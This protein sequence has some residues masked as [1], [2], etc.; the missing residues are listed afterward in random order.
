MAWWR[1]PS[2]QTPTWSREDDHTAFTVTIKAQIEQGVAPWQQSWTPGE[3][4]LP[5]HLVSG[6]AYRGVNA[7]HLSVVQTA[8]DYRDNRWAPATEIQALGGHVRPG[9]QAT[10]VL[11]DTMDDEQAPPPPGGEQDP[12]Q[13]RPP[14]VRCDAVFNVEQADGLSADDRDKK[15][16]SETHDLAER[17]IQE[18]GIH[19]THVHGDR[20]FYNRHTDKVTL[21]ERDQF[22]S[23]DGY[24]QTA[25]HELGHATGHPDRL[26]RATLTTGVGDFG[27][28]EYAREELRAEIAA[29]L[30]GV[31]VGVGHD[32]SRGA[33]YVQ[34]W[35]TALDDDPQEIDKAAAEAQHMSDYLLRQVRA[36]EQAIAQKHAALTATYSAGRS[37]QISPAPTARPRDP[38]LPVVAAPGPRAEDRHP[39]G[40]PPPRRARRSGAGAQVTSPVTR[41]P[42]PDRASQLAALAAL[43]WTGRDAEWIA[44]VCLQSGVFTRSQYGAYFKTGADRKPAGRFVRALL[45]KQLAVE[46]ARAIFPGGARAVHLTQKS[47]YRALGIPDVRHRRGQEATTQVLMRRL[48]SLDYV[49]ERPTLGWLPTEVEKVQRLVALGIDRGVLP[50]RTYGEGAQARKRFVALKCPVAVDEHTATFTYVDPGLTTDS[51]LRAWGVAHAPVWA[52]LRARTFAV[53]VVA[54][55]TGA[56]AAD[57]AEPVLKRWTRAGDGQGAADPTGPTQADPDIRQEIARLKDAISGGNRSLLGALG[58]FKTAVDRLMELR[59]LPEGTPT[60]EHRRA[61]IDRY[62]IWSTIRLVSPEA[63]LC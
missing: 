36:H 44:L 39:A 45:E 54:I 19:V 8:K 28:M 50:Y 40:D 37:P 51:E 15:S 47:I 34:G 46:D 56:K 41:P 63:A 59:Q 20:A 10:P 12:A 7:L 55:G 62:S 4:R 6:Q 33:P 35:L 60:K 31:R 30:T 17:V 29:M 11:C 18:S 42:V 61:A 14:M 53:H 48:L 27:S 43:G 26:N 22:A 5:E 3:R 38:P 21:P 9:E 25:L 13:A 52:A 1:T 23:A 2:A 49:I 24:Y 32:G 57:H 16:K 58:G